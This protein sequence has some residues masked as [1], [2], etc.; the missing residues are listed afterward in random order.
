MAKLHQC[1]TQMKELSVMISKGSRHNQADAPGRHPANI[2]C[3]FPLAYIKI[4]QS[5][6]YLIRTNEN[7]L[8]KTTKQPVLGLLLI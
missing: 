1:R 2:G 3:S 4:C 7:G 8:G 5:N 6:M